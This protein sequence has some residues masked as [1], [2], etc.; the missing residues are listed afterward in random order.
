ML[1]EA[2]RN[3]DKHARPSHVRV[4]VGRSDGAFVLE[5]RNDGADSDPDDARVEMDAKKA[6]GYFSNDTPLARKRSPRKGRG[7]DE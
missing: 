5:I 7:L 3:V 6:A 2:L 4:R 1:A